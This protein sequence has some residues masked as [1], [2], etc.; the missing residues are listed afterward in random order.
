MKT[1]GPHS[2]LT[3]TYSAIVKRISWRHSTAGNAA[4]VLNMLTL[5]LTPARGAVVNV[6]EKRWSD[7][8]KELVDLRGVEPLT[9]PVRWEDEGDSDD[10]E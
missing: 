2:T 5:L 6:D 3:G 10:G 4:P 1:S 9:S 8:H 7:Q